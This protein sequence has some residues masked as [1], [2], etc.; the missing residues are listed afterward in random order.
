MA[1][2]RKAKTFSAIHY[3]LLSWKALK[4]LSTKYSAKRTTSQSVL[5]NFF[6]FRLCLWVKSQDREIIFFWCV[7]TL[8]LL[9]QELFFCYWYSAASEST[10]ERI[11]STVSIQ[12]IEVSQIG[13]RKRRKDAVILLARKTLVI[14]SLLVLNVW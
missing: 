1:F 2:R 6:F 12:H 10:L 4:L 5:K 7:R 11:Q 3:L 14:S 8:D 13:I 9:F